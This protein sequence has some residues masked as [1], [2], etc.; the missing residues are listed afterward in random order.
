MTA[1]TCCVG[2]IDI[3]FFVGYIS[4][5][6]KAV[7]G[8]E[9][10][11]FGY[12]MSLQTVTYVIGAFL[13]PYTCEHLPRRFLFMFASLCFAFTISLIGP[14]TI[15]NVASGSNAGLAMLITSFPLL[16]IMQVF[17]F[18][19]I[20]PEMYDRVRA[21][22]EIKEGEDEYTDNELNNKVNMTY[23]FVYAGSLF[24][25]PLIG[26]ALYSDFEQDNGKVCNV[27]ALLNI[28]WFVVLFI[29]NGD[30]RVFK[31]NR[32]FHKKLHKLA[33]EPDEDEELNEIAKRT[34]SRAK[35]SMAMARHI[36]IPS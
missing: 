27:I 1:G 4:T 22:L 23:G 18:I 14:S 29:F 30:Y 17:V 24:I 10:D 32:E 16:G 34:Q 13:M 15:Y 28:A 11:K 35:L 31:E 19:P 3:Q 6:V 20:I 12:I 2:T 36:F 33:R 8:M 21:K 25:G 7:Y 9:E 5:M 26:G